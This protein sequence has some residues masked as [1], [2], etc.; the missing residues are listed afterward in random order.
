ME[1]LEEKNIT[2]E[3]IEES[4]E[5]VRKKANT[6]FNQK[7]YLDVKL[8]DNKDEKSTKI[9]LLTVDKDT[10]SPFLHIFM[11]SAKVSDKISKT[12][13][14]NYVC[15]E[16]TQGKFTEELGT[17]CPFCERRREYYQK[18]DEAKKKAESC[19][20]PTEKAK[21]LEQAEK[22]KK[23]SLELMPRQNSIV[24]C[25]ERGHEEDGPKFWKFTLRDDKA[26][27]EGQIRKLYK[28]KVEECKEQ[29]IEVENILDID[30]GRDLKV[31]IEAVYDKEGRRTGKT[32][33]TVMVFG[34]KKPLTP[35]KEQRNAWVNDPMIWS[36]AFVAKPY[37]YTNIIL[38]GGVPF[39][40]KETG[41]W[42]T[43]KNFKKEDGN[44]NEEAS[45]VP[46]DG[47]FDF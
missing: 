20:D 22:F 27:P 14:K 45:G 35:N 10:N 47:E 40:N 44:S 39:F 23:S 4:N 21:L 31:L 7:N 37:E 29:D 13:W 28:N 1:N 36:D 43:W 15:L 8:E 16:K 17:K 3:A 18:F 9:R 38:D 46:K 19:E 33:A 42:E 26:D 24:R 5:E 34:D 11:H 32:K 25:I 2:P 41:K 30:K 6:A 12:G